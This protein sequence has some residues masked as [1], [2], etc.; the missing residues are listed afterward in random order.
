MGNPNV[1]PCA[2]RRIIDINTPDVFGVGKP[3]AVNFNTFQS[4]VTVVGA[5]EHEVEVTYTNG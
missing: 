3:G 5:D 4:Y 2:W 1:F